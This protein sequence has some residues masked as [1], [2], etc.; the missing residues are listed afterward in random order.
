MFQESQLINRQNRMAKHFL[1]RFLFRGLSCG[2]SRWLNIYILLILGAVIVK[3]ALYLG[4]RY[5]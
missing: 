4:Y 2:K 3:D 5:G 1:Q